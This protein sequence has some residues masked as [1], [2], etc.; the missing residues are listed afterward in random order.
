MVGS[1]RKIALSCAAVIMMVLP[2][3]SI[4]DVFGSMNPSLSDSEQITA[5]ADYFTVGIFSD[6]SCTQI[7]SSILVNEINYITTDTTT[8]TLT[9]SDISASPLYFKIDNGHHS[10]STQNEYFV[11]TAT[12]SCYFDQTL[13]SN[14]QMIISFGNELSLKANSEEADGT[15]NLESG[16]YPFSFSVSDASVQMN[17]EPSDIDIRISINVAD[18]NTG[19]FIGSLERTLTVGGT[20]P[21]VDTDTADISIQEVNQ[22]NPYVS[23]ENNSHVIQDSTEESTPDGNTTVYVVEIKAKNQQGVVSNNSVNLDLIIPTGERF[24]IRCSGNR[25]T[26]TTNM[27]WLTITLDGETKN[28]GIGDFASTKFNPWSNTVFN[29]SKNTYSPKACY[30]GNYNADQYTYRAND[31]DYWLTGN[32]SVSL[33]LAGKGGVS[34]PSDIKLEIIFWPHSDD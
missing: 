14:A 31:K 3:V 34:I 20:V 32:E 15:V 6:E 19:T 28:V 29:T 4:G 12:F 21:I 22:E 9:T 5:H 11:V 33:H 23:G 30:S 10:W 24:C 25:A 16:V 1:I 7:P 2:I 18:G 17:S 27:F 13:V 26:N 8:R